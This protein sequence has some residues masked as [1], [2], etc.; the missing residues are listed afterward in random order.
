[1]E[2]IGGTDISS[3]AYT[4]TAIGSKSLLRKMT[5]AISV[6]HQ[7]VPFEFDADSSNPSPHSCN[8]F[9]ALSVPH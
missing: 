8:F 1:M 9:S 2:S 5:A 3:A 4:S 6:M 7:G